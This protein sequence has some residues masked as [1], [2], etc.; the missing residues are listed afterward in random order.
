MLVRPKQ[1][2]QLFQGIL[3]Y[4]ARPCL[5]D[6]AIEKWGR[7]GEGKFKFS[8]MEHRKAATAFLLRGLPGNSNSSMCHQGQMLSKQS[9]KLRL[10]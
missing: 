10:C 5:R 2:D 1:E 9:G 4:I 8:V 7:A 6:G 3:G